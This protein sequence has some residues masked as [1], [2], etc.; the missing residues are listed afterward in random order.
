M[1]YTDRVLTFVVRVVESR[2]GTLC[3]VVERVKTGRKEQVRTVEG[4][5]RVI[6]AMA[7]EEEAP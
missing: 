3:A 1:S 4:I 5:G 6:A 2:T 7:L